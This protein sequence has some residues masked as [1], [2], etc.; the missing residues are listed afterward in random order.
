MIKRVPVEM[1]VDAVIIIVLPKQPYFRRQANLN[2]NKT[3]YSCTCFFVAFAQTRAL[4]M[5]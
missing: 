2:R 5:T 1:E 4:E 3:L